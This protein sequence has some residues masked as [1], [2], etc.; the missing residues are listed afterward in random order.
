MIQPA[1]IAAGW[2]FRGSIRLYHKL[3]LDAHREAVGVG[4]IVCAIDKFL[5]SLLTILYQELHS[6]LRD[7]Y[8]KSLFYTI[9]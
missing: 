2:Y 5:C 8:T 7:N 9:M 1:R 4:N 3:S 6:I